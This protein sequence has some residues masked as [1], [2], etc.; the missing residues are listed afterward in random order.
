MKIK[1]PADI[2][3]NRE[4]IRNFKRKFDE[5]IQDDLTVL[6]LMCKKESKTNEPFL[7]EI[8]AA[9]EIQVFPCNDVKRFCCNKDNACILGV[10]M[11]YNVGDY[12]VVVTVYRHK[13]ITE[14]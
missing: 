1:S 3:R 13:K 14:K 12:Y 10:D 6:L 5:K 8:V 4:Q 2:P 7:R 11:T 9:P